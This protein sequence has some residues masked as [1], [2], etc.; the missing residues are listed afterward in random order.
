MEGELSEAI[1]R[2]P[3]DPILLEAVDDMLLR[4]SFSSF[5]ALQDALGRLPKRQFPKDTPELFIVL[6]NSTYDR[7]IKLDDRGIFRE[8]AMLEQSLGYCTESDNDNNNSVL[9]L[10]TGKSKTD[11]THTTTEGTMERPHQLFETPATQAKVGFF[12]KYNIGL[13]LS[14]ALTTFCVGMFLGFAMGKKSAIK[15]KR[16]LGIIDKDDTLR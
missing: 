7:V 13:I 2:L 10:D 14:T 11:V 5:Q 12:K 1:S 16:D 6:Y 3:D 9:D 15:E 8:I 4:S